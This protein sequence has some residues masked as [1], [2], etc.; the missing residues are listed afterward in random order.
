MDKSVN[1]LG[2]VKRLVPASWKRAAKDALQE[3]K[4]RRAIRQIAG[5]PL[6]EVPPRETLESLQFGWGNEGFAAQT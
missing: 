5:L 3:R 2:Q 1:R 4:F 6:G